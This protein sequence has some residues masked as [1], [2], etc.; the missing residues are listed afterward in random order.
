MRQRLVLA[1]I[2]LLAAWPFRAA[3]LDPERVLFGVDGA[4]ALLPWSAALSAAGA[5]PAGAIVPENPDLSDQAVQFYPLYRWVIR[6]W[7][8]G[9]PPLWCPGIYAGAPGI[10]NLQAGAL[11]PQVLFLAFLEWV[12]GERLFHWGF[13][14]LAW[15][16]VAAAGLG[17]CL[18]ARRLG[19]GLPGA[20][21]AACAFGFSG[22]ELLWL[23]HA[24]GHVPPFLPWILYFLEGIRI[25]RGRGK[26]GLLPAALAAFALA[27]AILGGHAETSFYIGAAA[28]LW[29]LAIFFEDR[30]AGSLALSALALG[31]AATAAAMLPFVEYL[32]LS[33]A[34]WVRE[35]QAAAARGAVDFAAL[36]LVFVLAGLIGLFRRGVLGNAAQ[37]TAATIGIA[38]CCAGAAFFLA[39][40]GLGVY[41]ALALVPDLYGRPVAGSAYRGEGT[42]VEAASAWLVFPALALALAALLDRSPRLARR[43]L[44]VGLGGVAFL[45]AIELPGILELYRFLP[46]VGLGATVRF[47]P[48]A[49]LFLGLL[50]GEALENA[51][52]RSR[53]AAAAILALLIIGSLVPRD[54]LPAFFPGR[55]PPLDASVPVTP[56]AGE[57]VGF[58]LVPPRSIDGVDAEFEG[59]LHPAVSVDRAR[60]V[61]ER[62]GAAGAPLAEPRIQI[63]LAF[64]PTASARARDAAPDAVRGAPEGAR[65]FRT[66]F[67]HTK[68]L[69]PGHWRFT[70]E[71]LKGDSDEPVA[72]R[73]VGV[74]TIERARRASRWTLAFLSLTLLALTLSPPGGLARAL[75]IGLAVLHGLHF[76][77]GLNPAVPRAWVFPPTRTEDILARELGAHRFFSDP[78]VLPPNTGLVRGLRSIEGYDAMDVAAFNA[79]RNYVFPPGFNTLLAWNARGVDYENQAFRLYG[80]KLLALREPIEHGSLELVA[81]PD[82]TDESRRA[83]TWIYRVKDPLPRAFCVPQVVSLDE[84]AAIHAEDPR[85]W[86]PLELAGL[87]QD[88]RPQRPFTSAMVSEP[89]ITNNEVRVAA[90][91]DGQGLLVVTEQAFPGWKAYVDGDER[92]I[93][94]ANLIFRAVALEPGKH[95]VVFRYEPGTLGVGLWISVLAAM[96]VLVIGVLGIMDRLHGERP[97]VAT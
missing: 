2:A 17:A 41:A 65:W 48:V 25:E 21:L 87:E 39:Q 35:E 57:L 37:A 58:A 33:A 45:L 16:R 18:L 3:L 9:D 4:A 7:L 8:G 50:A 64:Y 53:V 24:L 11:D 76:A 73:L 63:P 19:L 77:A 85:G 13:A 62:V 75:L 34:K 88:W 72:K 51:G 38:L 82:E 60:L 1:A 66:P 97:K 47:A 94:T 90:E 22:Y 42:Y 15:M 14:F 36:G 78:G 12:G 83:E 68:T 59:W 80:V 55:T 46:V 30:R 26:R 20:A 89:T 92:E 70:L 10:G 71:F 31:T 56:E 69:A 28:G 67:V 49:A 44:V 91:L 95:E 96:T 54:R 27:G 32:G 79:Y 43:P 61:L 74:S 52:R 81:S 84:L 29:G 93:L 5:A 6:S 40:R 86:D 23:N